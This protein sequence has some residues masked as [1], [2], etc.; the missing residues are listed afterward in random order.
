MSHI[1]EWKILKSNISIRIIN[2]G[3][4]SG[5]LFCDRNKVDEQ[6]AENC[7]EV[8]RLEAENYGCIQRAS[9][10]HNIFPTQ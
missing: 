9:I 3:I 5:F 2:R 8:E 6:V 10:F 7:I 1:E 4:E